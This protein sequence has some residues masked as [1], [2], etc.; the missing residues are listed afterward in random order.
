MHNVFIIILPIPHNL[1]PNPPI[2]NKKYLI[3]QRRLSNIGKETYHS[4]GEV[5][6]RSEATYTR[7]AITF[8]TGQWC[9]KMMESRRI[10]SA[11][12]V[13]SLA[14]PAPTRT[15]S[16]QPFPVVW[17]ISCPVTCEILP[18]IAISFPTTT[19][20]YS[21]AFPWQ[22]MWVNIKLSCLPAIYNSRGNISHL[23]IDLPNALSGCHK[24]VI[25]MSA[26]K[27]ID[28]NF[29]ILSTYV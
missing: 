28:G 25:I 12:M 14:Q 6:R 8:I 24:I 29:I 15:P 18:S 26:D 5:E 22:F 9:P 20:P 21:S 2:D 4:C 3:R 1:C 13:P 17:S 23:L 19:R 7:T 27:N 10:S 16:P 11:I